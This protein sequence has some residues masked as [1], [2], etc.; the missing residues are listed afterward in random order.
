VLYCCLYSILWVHGA[1]QRC[2][3]S[4]HKR[5]VLGLLVVLLPGC[6]A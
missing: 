2:M 5:F 4:L 1:R 3:F 6:Q